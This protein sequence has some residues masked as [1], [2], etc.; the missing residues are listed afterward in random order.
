MRLSD[1]EIQIFK[2]TILRIDDNAA[3]YLFGSRTDDKAKG[4]D[5][6]LLIISTKIGFEEK[7]K[8]RAGILSQIEEQKIDLIITKDFSTTF[9]KLIQPQLQCLHPTS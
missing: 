6:D 7:V 1:K 9:S 3:I 5:I 8:I 2:D 4:G